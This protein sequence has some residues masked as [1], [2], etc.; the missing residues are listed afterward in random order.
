MFREVNGMNIRSG[1]A[2]LVTLAFDYIAVRLRGCG[3]DGARDIIFITG[4]S[5]AMGVDVL[6]GLWY[7][8]V[9]GLKPLV[10]MFLL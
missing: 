9:L 2:V 3:Y 6:F 10:I 8:Q 1:A 5:W 7:W 4:S